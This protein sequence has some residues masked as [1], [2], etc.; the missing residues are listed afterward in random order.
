MVINIDIEREVC[1]EGEKCGKKL[2]SRISKTN[3]N[4]AL[5]FTV[6]PQIWG[7]NACFYPFPATLFVLGAL[8][9]LIL[10]D[11]LLWLD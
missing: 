9:R 2:L 11:V 8:Y 7:G 4:F 6:F 1:Q 10:I 3:T 5:N